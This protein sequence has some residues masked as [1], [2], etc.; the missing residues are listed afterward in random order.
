MYYVMIICGFSSSCVLPIDCVA[1]AFFFSS[2]RRH[3][4]CALVTGV[5]TCALPIFAHVLQLDH[6]VAE[7]FARRDENL[8][9]FVSA[10]VIAGLQF[11]QPG[12]TRLALGAAAARILSCPFQL[13]R[14]RFLTRLFLRFFLLQ[15]FLFLLQPLRVVALPRN[16]AA[17]IEF[18]Y[19]LGGVVEEVAIMGRSEERR[20]GKECVSE[21]RSRWW[22]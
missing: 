17:A 13:F 5:Q 12:Q 2:R 6:V 8:V 4:R 15:A 1:A 14:N 19:P 11:L 3:T 10:L 16:A 18:E 21:C 20:V 9:G 22:Q 7:A